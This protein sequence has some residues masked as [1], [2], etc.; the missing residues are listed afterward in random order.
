[1]S[2]ETFPFSCYDC[3]GQSNILNLILNRIEL[4]DRSNPMSG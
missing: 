2:E 1:M 4:Y 3:N